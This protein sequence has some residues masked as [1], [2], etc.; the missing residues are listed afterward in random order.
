MGSKKPLQLLREHWRIILACLVLGLGGAL[1]VTVVMPKT[2]TATATVYVSAVPGTDANALLESG[3]LSEQR[4]KSY[5]ALATSER[6]G[7]EVVADL[8]LGITG[9]QLLQHVTVTSPAG[10]VVLSISA[11]ATTPDQAAQ[12]AN[13]VSTA[14][15]RLV[16]DLERPA[17]PTGPRIITTQ[18]VE[19]ASPPV[20]AEWPNPWLN[21]PLGAVVGLLIGLAVAVVRERSDTSVKSV[22]DLRRIARLP[23][24]GR[25]PQERR[26]GRQPLILHTR[27]LSPAAEAFRQLRTSLRFLNATQRVNAVMLTSPLRNEGRTTM[28]CNLALAMTQVGRRVVIVDADLRRPRVADILQLPGAPGL[29]EV[30]AGR[31]K[32]PNVIRSWGGGAFD[33][34]T[35]GSVPTNPSEL[36]DSPRMANLIL[37]LRTRYDL[38]LVDAPPLLPVTDAVALTKLMDGSVLL[39]RHGATTVEQVHAA[40]SA[41]ATVSARILGTVLT[42]APGTGLQH[43]VRGDDRVQATQ[44][45]AVAFPVPPLTAE[46]ALL[47]SDRAAD[48]M[49]LEMNGASDPRRPSPKPRS[50]DL[51]TV[52]IP[53]P[54]PATAPE[55]RAADDGADDAPT[56][57]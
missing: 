45:D 54:V 3:Q 47:S 55:T 27:P 21:V 42:A 16:S 34:V 29:S 25:I 18:V 22:E 9:E 56:S 44:A 38:V 6:I 52:Q 23:V 33:V 30:L 5:V 14:F 26:L 4:M 1:L 31:A 49:E 13:G 24:L 48:D 20:Q 32:L 50:M 10:T 11:S 39:A 40:L 35:S 37:D 2:Y 57:S 46:T 7:R 12:I 15:G 53:V 43:V 28:V 51:P 8:G 36:L 41:L 19:P 17:N